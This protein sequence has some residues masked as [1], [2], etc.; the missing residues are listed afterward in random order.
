MCSDDD[1]DDDMYIYIYIYQICVLLYVFTCLQHLNLSEVSCFEVM[2]VSNLAASCDLTVK[3]GF[4]SANM[5]KLVNI[6][7]EV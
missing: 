7:A 3:C 1:D 2:K 6:S 4:L 5:F